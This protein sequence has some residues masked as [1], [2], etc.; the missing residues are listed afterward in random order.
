[1]TG[2]AWRI[3]AGAQKTRTG[4]RFTV[5]APAASSVDVELIEPDG[6]RFEAI[7]RGETGV[8]SG[9]I[10]DV[11]AGAHY[12]FRV[13]GE[14]SFPDP[15]SRYQPEG[16]HGPSEIVDPSAFAWTDSNWKGLVAEN[17]AIYELHVGTYTRI[18]NV[19][20]ACR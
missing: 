15:Y 1:M 6:S 20:R 13:D 14:G 18:G 10:S 2:E 17:R 16:V 4:V 3:E 5:W 7:E 9:E 11:N 19:R 12:R 8:W